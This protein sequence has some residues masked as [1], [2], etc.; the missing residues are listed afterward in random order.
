MRDYARLISAAVGSKF[1]VLNREELSQ[2]LDEQALSMSG[3]IRDD[4]TV[5][6]GVIEG[7]EKTL[8]LNLGCIEMRSVIELQCIDNQTSV[9]DWSAMS[10]GGGIDEFLEHLLIEMFKPR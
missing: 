1:K 5:E 3:L 9:V 10:V 7:A 8:L 2:I 6:A 4:K